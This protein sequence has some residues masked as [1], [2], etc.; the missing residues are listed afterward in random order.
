V[1]KNFLI[2]SLFLIFSFFSSAQQNTYWQQ[3]VIYNIDVSLNDTAKELNGF[4]SMQ[5]ENNSPDTLP[6]IWIHLWPNAYKNDRTAFSDQLI[7]NGNTDFY[8]CDDEKKGY[9]NKINFKVNNITATITDHPIHQD[10]IKLILPTPLLPNSSATIETPFH[11]KLPYNFSRGGYVG[12][13]FHITQWYPKPAVYDKKG[14]HEMPYLEQGEFYSEFGKYTVNI[15]LQDSFIVASTGKL[16][17]SIEHENLK[18]LTYSQD[19]VHDFAWFADK[20]FI[21]E[22]DT[23]MIGNKIININAYHY[24]SENNHWKNGLRYIKRAIQTK[25]NWVGEY[26]YETIS[27]VESPNEGGGGMEYPTITLIDKTDESKELDNLIEH[28]IGHNW[29]YGILGSNER[30]YPWMDEGMNSYY[31]KRYKSKF[32]P[33]YQNQSKLNNKMPFNFEDLITSTLCSIHKDQPINTT[34]ENFSAV[35]YNFVAYNKTAMWMQL[36]ESQLTQPLLD[37]VMKAYF[38]EWKF[39]HPYPEDFKKTAEQISKQDISEEFA[40]LNTKGNLYLPQKKDIRLT[41]FFSLKETEKHNYIS[42]MPMAGYNNYDKFMI[43]G[44]IHNYSLPI[45]KF[46]FVVAPLFATASKQFVYIGKSTYNIFPGN[47]DARLTFSLT[48]AAFSNNVFIDSTGTKNYLRFRKFVPGIK[49]VFSTPSARSTINKYIQWKTYFINETALNFKRDTTQQLDV[50]TYPVK[51]SYINQLQ[52]VYEQNRKLYPYKAVLLAEQGKGFVKLGF[53][54]NYYF[55]YKKQGGMN[56][57]FFAGKFMYTSAQ[58]YLSRYETDRY[59][60]NLSGA[61]GS[62]DYTYNNYFVGRNAFE[63]MGSKQIM[64]KDGGFKVRTEL[65][66][67]KIG[68]TDDWLST[69]NFTTTIPDNVN[70]LSVL[71]FKL[72]IKLFFDL[73]TYAEAWKSNSTTQKFLYDAGLQLSMLKNT[74]NIYFPVLY[75]KPFTDYFKSTIGEKRFLKN[76]AFSIDIQNFSLRTIVPQINF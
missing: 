68:K 55:N 53:T 30:D 8:F 13:A 64:M 73:G 40:L 3:H 51:K 34:S 47:K 6:F 60:L 50:I 25:S 20:H 19:S 39:K 1:L 14:W 36:L 11:V 26:P 7:E 23:L 31:D 17:S 74:V 49:Y 43:G 62:E 44:L 29:F 4:V 16:I 70:P 52:F 41:A 56:V 5:Y 10:I 63:G 61:N 45:N 48:A 71:P 24:P 28:E 57:R 76:I 33:R 75:S 32:Y 18:K 66:S 46:Q 72:P 35:N 67:D 15:T 37:S 65:L 12:K 59:H 58:T 69:L 42:I 27:V 38:Q 22:H 54:G 2:V 21:T 9:V